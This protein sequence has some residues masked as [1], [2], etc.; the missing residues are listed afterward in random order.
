MLFS[1]IADAVDNVVDQIM[2]QLKSVSDDV[3]SP[4][5][6]LVGVITGG[7]WEG[8]DATAMAEE[9]TT[10]V[11][12]M[13]AE[14]IAAIAGISTGVGNAAQLVQDTDAKAEG[15]VGDLVSTFSSIF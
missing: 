8:D 13:V 7:A 1:F 15:I 5:N 9:I 6:S 10:V 4:I 3:E 14:L 12:P 11:L 2:G